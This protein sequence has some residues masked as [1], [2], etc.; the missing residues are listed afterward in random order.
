MF[1]EA[2][3][4]ATDDIEKEWS[5]GDARAKFQSSE[6]GNYWN[7]NFQ[8]GV[9]FIEDIFKEDYRDITPKEYLDYARRY[10]FIFLTPCYRRLQCKVSPF[11]GAIK[12]TEAYFS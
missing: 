11:K 8:V 3:L 5:I 4:S 9:N 7:V 10:D 6:E 12:V 1:K 2:L